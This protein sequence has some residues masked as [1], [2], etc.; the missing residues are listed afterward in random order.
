MTEKEYRSNPG[1]SR[2]ELWKL[3]DRNGGTPEKFL[4][5]KSHPKSPTKEM[6]FGQI[7]HKLLLQ[8]E[9]FDSEFAVYPNVDR[10][11][12]EGKAAIAEFNATLDNR[13]PID[14]DS[15]NKAVSM[16][17][18][19]DIKR[20]I[21]ST[22]L[23]EGKRE[24]PAFWTDPDTNEPCK[25]RF[26]LVGTAAGRYFIL[27]YKT[28]SNASNDAFKKSAVDHGYYLQAAMYLEGFYQSNYEKSVLQAVNED[29]CIPFIFLA[30]EKEEPFCCNIFITD[31]ESI[32][33][34]YDIY[35][36]LLGKYHYCKESGNW[37]GYLGRDN[38]LNT[39]DLPAWMKSGR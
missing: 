9:D 14:S 24:I 10:R 29:T 3:Y 22:N 5:E 18:S 30:Q 7:A 21:S 27:D 25:C 38:I 6:L 8:P 33:K 16:I 36:E 13:T 19:D 20:I 11:T 26:D 17:E 15:Y 23:L 32:L 2:S 12:T 31:N 34:G 37:Y 35:R 4:W 28:C 39:L 1:I